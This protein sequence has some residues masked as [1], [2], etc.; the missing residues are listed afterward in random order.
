MVELSSLLTGFDIR[1]Q[2]VVCEDDALR[3]ARSSRSIEIQRRVAILGQRCGL[4]SD[5]RLISCDQKNA[6]ISKQWLDT[7]KRLIEKLGR[8]QG[9][10]ARILDDEPQFG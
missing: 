10:H 6:P 9:R 7:G 4:R 8:N 3:S 2:V 5:K 1:R